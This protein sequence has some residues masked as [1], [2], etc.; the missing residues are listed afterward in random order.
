MT[1]GFKIFKFMNSSFFLR[2]FLF[3]YFFSSFF[4]CVSANNSLDVVVNEIAWMGTKIENIESRNWWR[5]EWLE[6]YNNT[7]P[8][9]SLNG[10][11]IEL[12]RNSLDWDLAL[13]GNVPGQG[14]FLI[15]ASDK[16]FS[17]YDLNYSNLGGKLNNDGQKIIL[18]NANGQIID[19]IDCSSGWVNGNNTTKQTMERKN[20]QLPSI[21]QNWQTSQVP[22]GTPKNKNSLTQTA[23]SNEQAKSEFKQESLSTSTASTS[24]AST[25]TTSTPTS[26]IATSTAASSPIAFEKENNKT[27]FEN[28]FY[29]TGIII[30]EIL[31]AP[32]GADDIE[33]WIEIKNLN[34][35]EVSLSDWK[36][37]D[38]KGS[39]GAY[40]FPK[41]TKIG[42]NGFLVF[43]RPVTKITLNNNGD[44]LSLIQPNGNVLDFVNYEKAEKGKSY[45]RLPSEA[46]LS[47]PVEQPKSDIWT[48]T[49]VLTP[50]TENVIPVPQSLEEKTQ[51]KNEGTK[52]SNNNSK[53]NSNKKFTAM[54]AEQVPDL[55]KP[56]LIFLFIL[57]VA[58]ITGLA[59]FFLKKRLQKKDE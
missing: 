10:W 58:I 6:L 55:P 32:E 39:I 54:A 1:F 51:E 47:E 36:I 35:Q 56:L 3:L 7:Q 50:G 13:K 24:T 28:V 43:S 37:Q 33:E 15:V 34:E 14:Y 46:S 40:V 26:I 44:G 30:N 57:I 21:P 11:K 17:N 31:P 29:P 52:N 18:K 2:I 22:G 8:P 48:W 9:I 4:S 49:S 53:F 25:S 19:E 41:G 27:N 16:I 23:L 20:S 38:T 12:Y 59:I 42:A 45:D 5:Y